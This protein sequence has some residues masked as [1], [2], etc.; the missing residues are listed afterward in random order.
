MVDYGVESCPNLG[1][2]R[3]GLTGG[4][5]TML[6]GF[7]VVFLF[8]GCRL[9]VP[10]VGGYVRNFLICAPFLRTGAY[11]SASR[12]HY[13]AT[14]GRVVQLYNSDQTNFPCNKTIYI[15]LSVYIGYRSTGYQLGQRP[16]KSYIASTGWPLCDTL[17]RSD[18]NKKAPNEA[19]G[20]R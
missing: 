15:S 18:S 4:H 20:G 9:D 6:A 14:R 8:T 11:R 13:Q 19:A 2:L 1:C 10:F 16:S 7:L 3:G 12:R 17:L 5:P